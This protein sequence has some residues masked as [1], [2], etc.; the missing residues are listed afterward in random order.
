MLS[1]KLHKRW[2]AVELTPSYST[3]TAAQ[4]IQRRSDDVKK[5]KF[6]KIIMGF[7]GTSRRTKI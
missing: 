1:L 7:V 4:L 6:M 3:E 2:D 5:T